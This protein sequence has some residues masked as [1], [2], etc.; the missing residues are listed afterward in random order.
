MPRPPFL[1]GR[2]IIL[3]T[4]FNRAADHIRYTIGANVVPA[5]TRYKTPNFEFIK[6]WEQWKTEPIPEWQHEEWKAQGAFNKG[7]AIVLGKLFHNNT[8]LFLNGIDADN[9]KAIDELCTRNGKTISIQELAGWTYVEQ[10]DDRKDRMH[11]LVYSE[12]RPFVKKSSDQ[13]KFGSELDTNEIPA[14][15]VKNEGSIFYVSPSIHRDKDTGVERPYQIIGTDI[16][17]LSNSFENNIDNI[18]RKYNI[19]YLNGNGDG[20]ARPGQTPIEELFK[21]GFKVLEGHNR[22]E[23]LL[24]VMESLITRNRNILSSD[25][26]KNLCHEWN[27]KTCDPPLDDKEFEK[28]WKCATK[29]IVDKNNNNGNNG[30]NNNNND[31]VSKNKSK[32]VI[33]DITDELLS[34]YIFK[35]LKDTEEI[36]YYDIRRGIYVTGGESLIKSESEKITPDI[37]T[38]QVN[39]IINHIIRRTL[40][41]RAEFDS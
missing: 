9:Q 34:R 15:E 31:D 30:N 2:F 10:H 29:F 39:E 3:S 18:L 21:P 13:S 38:N 5:N 33:L 4:D 25:Q 23:A 20:A 32:Q 40:I 17:V 36:Y 14:I 16:P 41:D 11:L 26:I 35:T 37:S 1:G 27:N 12:G 28:Q 6:T 24:R 22:H 7:L 8:H 19:P